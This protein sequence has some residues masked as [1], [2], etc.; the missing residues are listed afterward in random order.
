MSNKTKTEL[1][2]KFKATLPEVDGF[3]EDK[4]YQIRTSI[5]T[6]E[7]LRLL[8]NKCLDEGVMRIDV[9]YGHSVYWRDNGMKFMEKCFQVTMLCRGKN[10]Q[11]VMTV[12][13]NTHPEIHPHFDIKEVYV[14]EEG[15]KELRIQEKYM[16]SS[17]KARAAEAAKK[18]EKESA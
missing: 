3:K 4:L 12:A 10:L 17:K 2:T 6:E 14:L 15:Q 8:Q 16:E 13:M 7:A 18:A 9:S 1:A 11:D 5:R